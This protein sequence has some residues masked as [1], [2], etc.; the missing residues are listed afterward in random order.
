MSIGLGKRILRTCRSL[1]ATGVVAALGLVLDP[2]S[3]ALAQT[4]I[5]T[6][7]VG[8]RQEASHP[9]CA[10]SRSQD[11]KSRLAWLDGISRR[12]PAHLLIHAENIYTG[13][14]DLPARSLQAALE[15]AGRQGVPQAQYNLL[16]LVYNRWVSGEQL[17]QQEVS[18]AL[19]KVQIGTFR[20]QLAF[21][22][23]YI[24]SL[25]REHV[26]QVTDGPTLEGYRLAAGYGNADAAY[27]YVVGV[28]QHRPEQVVADPELRRYLKKLVNTLSGR[29]SQLMGL[30]GV[31]W[32]TGFFEGGP[33]AR[34]YYGQ[35]YKRVSERMATRASGNPGPPDRPVT[36]VDRDAERL[37]RVQGLISVTIAVDYEYVCQQ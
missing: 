28:L 4:G 1:S 2:A 24:Y 7:R 29:S 14:L 27:R 22:M 35:L 16:F 26:L 25:L 3:S 11:R 5:P 10:Q 21:K 30:R 12:E 20:G 15:E 13:Q 32:S 19:A 18:D 8:G 31:L 17:S 23:G 37:I 36:K 9:L 33:E 34:T 6:D